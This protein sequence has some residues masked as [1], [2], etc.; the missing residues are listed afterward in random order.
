MLNQ[1]ICMGRLVKDPEKRVTQTGKTVT[2]FTIACDRDQVGPD[3]KKITDFIDCYAWDKTG[4]FIAGFFQKGRLIAV[5]GRLQFRGWTDKQ[6]QKRRNAE[7]LVG[8][9]EFCGDKRSEYGGG[10]GGQMTAATQY[11]GDLPVIPDDGDCPF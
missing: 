3:G 8:K 5:C 4:E 1:F 10:N 2:S 6:G 9:A 11:A 7:I